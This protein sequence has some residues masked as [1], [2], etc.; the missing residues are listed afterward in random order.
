MFQPVIL[1][2]PRDLILIDQ[3]QS[4]FSRYDSL[5]FF[6]VFRVFRG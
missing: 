1:V 3:P 6:R 2:R 4:I 5:V